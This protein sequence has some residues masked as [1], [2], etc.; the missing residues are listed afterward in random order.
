MSESESRVHFFHV[1]NRKM[2]DVLLSEP[3]MEQFPLR[4]GMKISIH[5]RDEEYEVV[6]WNFH[7][8]HEDEKSGL[9]IILKETSTTAAYLDGRV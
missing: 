2:I 8:G 9:R 1:A 3:S 6:D 4:V 5:S 7:W